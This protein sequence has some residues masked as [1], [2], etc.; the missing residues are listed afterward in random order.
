MGQTRRMLPVAVLLTVLVTACDAGRPPA[1]LPTAAAPT[2]TADRTAATAQ[3]EQ[4]LAREVHRLQV[5]IHPREATLRIQTAAGTVRATRT[6]FTGRLPGG[7]LVLTL[8]RP[9]RHTLTQ[10]VLL[11]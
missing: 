11:A 2:S 6:P 7:H 3:A 5:V 8:P 9:G 1:R 4:R 10:P